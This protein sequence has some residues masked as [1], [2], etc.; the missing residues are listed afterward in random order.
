[1]FTITASLSFSI[2]YR[3]EW[4]ETGVVR[5]MGD[6]YLP[7]SILYRIEWVETS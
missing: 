4:V 2:L 1:M 3:I 7:F 5:L 6:L